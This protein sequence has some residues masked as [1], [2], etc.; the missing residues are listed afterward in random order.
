MNHRL[1]W[2]L[3]AF[4][5]AARPLVRLA[6]AMGL[7]HAHLEDMLRDL[8]L[9]EAR[10]L[11]RQR[12]VAQPN[13]SQLSLTTGLN[14]K[15]VTSRVRNPVDALPHTE[16]SVSAY[17]FTLWHQL[18]LKNPQLRRLPISAAGAEHSFEAVA[19]RATRGNFHYRTVLDEMI[20]LGMAVSHGQDAE[21]TADAFIPSHD[22]QSML[23]FVGDHGRDHLLAAVSNTV[24]QKPPFL[25]RSVY[26]T[27]LD[28]QACERIHT[29]TRERWNSLHEELVRSLC[30]A[31]DEAQGAGDQ[32]IRIGIYTYHEHREPPPDAVKGPLPPPAPG[33]AP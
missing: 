27:G 16:S 1:S 12:G 21:L 33:T 8:L 22:L 30:D 10:R 20:R 31:V 6:L 2:A 3:S 19:Q 11:W 25:E 32:R 28:A 24:A 17:S 23:A 9:D 18:A 29:L 15:E 5:R 26:A 7:K 4:Y 14:R 13:I